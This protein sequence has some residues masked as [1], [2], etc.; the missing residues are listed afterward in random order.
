MILLVIFYKDKG[1]E[2][3]QGLKRE[4]EFGKEEK[5]KRDERAKKAKKKG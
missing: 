1:K 4:K 2:E 3:K 5:V